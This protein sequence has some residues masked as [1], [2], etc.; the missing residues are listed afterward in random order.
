A[1]V[2]PGRRACARPA[3][4]ADGRPAILPDGRPAILPDGRPAP[5]PDADSAR[6]GEPA[7]LE[8][9]VPLLDRPVPGL[10]RRHPAGECLL[11]RFPKR[12]IE[13]VAVRD[14]DGEIPGGPQ[15]ARGD[16]PRP[17]FR[18]LPRAGEV[19]IGGGGPRGWEDDDLVAE[20]EL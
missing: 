9:G 14:D 18:A 20:G 17:V 2:R 8:A 3:S 1:A 11:H 10:L 19:R 4:P 16:R 13:F 6:P 12:S 7:A 15:F 5:L